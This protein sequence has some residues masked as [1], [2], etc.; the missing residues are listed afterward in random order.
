MDLPESLRSWE[1]SILD[2]S[3]VGIGGTSEEHVSTA[4]DSSGCALSPGSMLQEG[5]LFQ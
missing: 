3:V 2:T 1:P 5:T 4:T